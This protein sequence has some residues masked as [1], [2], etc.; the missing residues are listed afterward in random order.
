MAPPVRRGSLKYLLRQLRRGYRKGTA[1][2][3]DALLE[4]GRQV[5][6]PDY[7]A[8]PN[9]E[10]EGTLGKI[11]SLRSE[12]EGRP[13][14]G[15]IHACV[16]VFIRRG[17][18]VDSHWTLFSDLW[19]AEHQALCRELSSRWLI[20]ALDTMVDMAPPDRAARAMAA[21]AMFNM[22]RFS[23]SELRLRGAMPVGGLP[24]R[25]TGSRK[26]QY[27]WDGIEVYDFTSGD[28]VHNM[29]A[30]LRRLLEPDHVLA[31][32]FEALL[33]RAIEGES[34]LRR[35]VSENNK[36]RIR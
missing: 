25:A 31:A 4:A 23:E 12:F 21:V 32:I 13:G 6:G 17:Y 8:F 10:D 11:A 7:Q 2:A 14:L 1:P 20:S 24:G 19:D 27:L 22:M 35:I 16:I 9:L 18:K 3:L 30:R 15:Y 28:A 33:A 36:F 29:I 26:G 34:L 5:V